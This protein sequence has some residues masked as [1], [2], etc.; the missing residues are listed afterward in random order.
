MRLVTPGSPSG[1][2]NPGNFYPGILHGLSLPKG[3]SSSGAA[4]VPFPVGCS[5]PGSSLSSDFFSG[6]GEGLPFSRL[7]LDSRV[8][9]PEVLRQTTPFQRYTWKRTPQDCFEGGCGARSTVSSNT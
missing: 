2:L 9:L 4:F 6:G 3:L 1:E 7:H 5:F 8:Q